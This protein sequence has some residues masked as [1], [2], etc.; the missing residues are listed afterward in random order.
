V[1]S[2]ARPG[3]NISGLTVLL[4][5]LVAKEMEIL[6]EALPQATRIGVLFSSTAPSHIP[7][8]RAIEAAAAK[9]GVEIE[10]VPV[11][12]VEDLDGAF[13]RMDRARVDGFLVVASSLT[14]SAR[15]F[16]AELVLKHRLPA[17]FGTKD[18]VVAG[19]FMSYAP[20]HR[21]LTRRSAIYIDKILR[22][23]KASD[24]PVEQASKYQLVINLKT[25]QTLGIDVSPTLLSRA[26]EV[27]E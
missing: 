10:A 17:M 3:G 1:A 7:A 6:K 14:F 26:D 9:L 4:T 13:A 19:G 15:G 20:D 8:L 25:A 5:D 21:D 18:D 27:I 12:S 11:R 24:L 23:A 2:L 16:L 22:G